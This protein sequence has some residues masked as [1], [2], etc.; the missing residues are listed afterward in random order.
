MIDLAH[1]YDR[2]A[3]PG[4]AIRAYQAALGRDASQ[5]GAR[6]GLARLLDGAGKRKEA[7]PMLSEAERL[8]QVMQN[9]EGLGTAL[10]ARSLME[11][12]ADLSIA[13]A[14]RAEASAV[15]VS[16]PSLL[17]KA[18]LRQAQRLDY[19]GKGEEATLLA[20]EAVALAEEKGLGALA[21]LGFVDLGMTPFTHRRYRAAEAY[22]QRAIQL[23]QRYGAKRTE[24]WAKLNMGHLY[25][26]E[27]ETS[28][29]EAA[30]PILG[31]A[32][33]FF[34]SSGEKTEVLRALRYRGEALSRLGR[35]DEAMRALEELLPLAD[36]PADIIAVKTSIAKTAF[37]GGKF[38]LAAPLFAEAARYYGETSQKQL[39][40][41]YLMYNARALQAGGRLDEAASVLGKIMKDGPVNSAVGETLEKELAVLDF[42]MQRFER[43]ITRIEALAHKAEASGQTAVLRSLRLSLCEKY[44]QASR[45]EKAIATC[46]PLLQSLAGQPTKLSVVEQA[47]GVAYSRQ[48]RHDEAV[49]HS[50]AAVNLASSA[51]SYDDL[52]TA[53]IA[54]V[55]ALHATNNAEWRT[56]RTELDQAMEQWRKTAGAETVEGFFSLPVT[57]ARLRAVK[58]LN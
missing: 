51:K 17:I 11:D 33:S 49:R 18:K 36:T 55:K 52:T 24:A 32:A 58:N 38:K 48:G 10:L 46:T 16:S 29:T 1:L 44:A 43:S 26:F 23:A 37:T 6:M 9:T 14:K 2:A 21:A 5:P 34:R 45:P 39:E 12:D 27:G 40:Q 3:K 25:F 13:L 30:I 28:R 41:T 56:V 50:R 15:Q 57:S 35:V 8:Y 47:L 20:N 4:E 31:A 19:Q 22:F 42:Q 7:L 54:L 53:M